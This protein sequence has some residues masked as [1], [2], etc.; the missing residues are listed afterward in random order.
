MQN[1]Q[2]QREIIQVFSIFRLS[3]ATRQASQPVVLI[4]TGK[5]VEKC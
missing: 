3:K 4:H 1:Q 5:N 2:E